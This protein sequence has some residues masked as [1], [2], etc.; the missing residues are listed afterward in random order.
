MPQLNPQPWFLLLLA[1]WLIFSAL[2]LPGILKTSYPHTPSMKSLKNNL[3]L[4]M[5][6]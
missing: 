2:T 1:M 6:D 4:K 3:N 5:K